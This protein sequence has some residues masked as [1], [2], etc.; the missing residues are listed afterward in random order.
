MRFAIP[1]RSLLGFLLERFGVAAGVP[2]C[3]VGGRVHASS[4]LSRALQRGYQTT[5]PEAWGYTKPFSVGLMPRSLL[6]GIL[7]LALTAAG[8]LPGADSVIAAKPA[9]AGLA[10]LEVS[11]AGLLRNRELKRSLLL[12]LGAQ[13]G[14]TFDA[15]AIEDAAVLLISALRS[16]GYQNPVVE[17]VATLVDGTVRQLAFDASLASWLP[18]PL[19]A[20]AVKFKLRPG[21][22]WHI[23]TVEIIGLKVLAEKTVRAFFRTEEMLFVSA[24]ANSYSLARSESAARALRDELHE[25]GYAD[26]VVQAEAG[27]INEATG[28]VALRVVVTE[29]L[30]WQVAKVRYEGQEIETAQLP[31]STEWIGRAWSVAL[32]QAIQAKIRRAYYQLGFPDVVVQMVTEPGLVRLNQK[33]VT[34]VAQIQPGAHVQVGQVRFEGNV[35]THDFV[36]SRR[37]EVPSGAP[38]NSLA[39]AN[40]RYRISR[41]GV[42]D[43]VD[44]RYEP[45]DGPVRDPV[46]TLKESQRYEANLLLG[47]GSYEQLRG[48]IEL[49]QINIFGR[50][51]Q[52]LLRLVQSMK[53]SSGDYTYSVPELFGESIDGAVRIFGV[54]REEIAFLRQEY[55]ASFTL[56]RAIPW[57][58]AMGTAGY[59]FQ[60]LRNH[61]NALGTQTTDQ[62]QINVGSVDFGLSSDH[63]DN[64][65]RPRRGYRWFTQVELAGRHLGGTAEYERLELGL[66]YHAP[67]GDGRWIHLGLTHGVITT[68]G[69]AAAAMPVNK[70]FFPGGD[71][72]IRGYQKGEAAP[73][74]LDGLYV[75]AKSYVLLNVELEQALTPKWSA[76]AFVDALGIAAHL[77][78]YPF[79][80]QLYSAGLGVRYQTLIGPLRVEYGHNLNPR[81]GDPKGTW[82]ISIGYPF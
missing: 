13:R 12:L 34:V 9:V 62:S 40:A 18:R 24:K 64:P 51:H 4:T 28:A 45:A 55:G 66:S 20:R 69:T 43:E 54:Q 73:R 81:A 58:R 26:A 16:E 29:G 42:F 7:L 35:I 65:M 14:V 32:Q 31:P 56:K 79:S 72:S 60:S 74:G 37:V 15:N 33:P 5:G 70:L 21:V 19:A 57:L 52:S 47:Y 41:L 59:T 22:R 30:R 82:Q 61:D 80:E 10:T 27:T 1:Q 68:L 67:W 38:L 36:L 75:G 17:I 48:G 77:S 6:R 63:R 3:R 39:L 44:L 23:D 76:V 25:R 53:S 11:G 8:L 71:N 46:F 2:A 50:A 49:R 78:D